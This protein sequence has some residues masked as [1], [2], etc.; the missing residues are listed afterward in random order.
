MGYE[1]QQQV[2]PTWGVPYQPAGMVFNTIPTPTFTGS[3]SDEEIALIAQK[4]PNAIDLNVSQ[5]DYLRAVCNH[6]HNG[7]DVAKRLNDGRM[8]CPICQAIWDDSRVSKEEI[9]EAC[10]LIEEQMQNAKWVGEFTPEFIREY[11]SMSEMLKKF[12]D[13]W[14]YAVKS[15]E[16]YRNANPYQT[17]DESNVYN[18]FN[19]VMYGM[20]YSYQQP[21]GYQQTPY[22]NQPITQGMPTPGYA[23]Q[24]YQQAPYGQQPMG[25]QQAPYGQQPMAPQ[26][27]PASQFVNPMQ[28]PVNPQFTDQAN[29]MMQGGYYAPQQSYYAPQG[30]Q[31]QQAQAPQA[32]APAVDNNT[33]ADG[34]GNATTE[35]SIQLS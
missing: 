12:P 32:S 31:Q 6:K 34:A 10:S 13:I 28:A 5:Q 21:R 35:S 4:K 7:V 3:L 17:A 8:W 16:K 20:P 24:G 11:F 25:Y 26:G 22:M 30:Y 9:E 23:P 18:M 33:T 2:F 15:Y 19:S 27:M 1:T 29:M 14:E